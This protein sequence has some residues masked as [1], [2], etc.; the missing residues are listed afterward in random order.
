[1]KNWLKEFSILVV[2]LAIWYMLDTQYNTLPVFIGLYLIALFV[3]NQ[4]CLVWVRY[5]SCTRFFLT[6]VSRQ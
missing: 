1:M 6:L 2:L 4:Q 5:K 3:M